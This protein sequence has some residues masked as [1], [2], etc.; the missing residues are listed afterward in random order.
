MY[1]ERHAEHKC[2]SQTEHSRNRFE[3]R[4]HNNIE[5]VGEHVFAFQTASLSHT[6]QFGMFS[7]VVCARLMCLAFDFIALYK[8]NLACKVQFS[9]THVKVVF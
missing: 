1:A 3:R 2:Q 7:S 8:G 5:Y 6:I 9:L 4:T